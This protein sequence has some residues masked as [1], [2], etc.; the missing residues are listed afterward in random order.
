MQGRLGG[1]GLG[2]EYSKVLV[3]GLEIIN[4]ERLYKDRVDLYQL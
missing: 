4:R 1:K 3:K 2:T